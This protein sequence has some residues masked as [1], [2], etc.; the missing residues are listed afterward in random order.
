MLANGVSV[1]NNSA[2]PAD[3]MRVAGHVHDNLGNQYLI[4]PLLVAA[5]T[6]SIMFIFLV[7]IDLFVIRSR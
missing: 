7:W 1:Y 3:T 2:G 5:P 4:T 6:V